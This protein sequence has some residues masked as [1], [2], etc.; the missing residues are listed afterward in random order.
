VA[1]KGLVRCRGAR[2]CIPMP[3]RALLNYLLVF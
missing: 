3:A 1:G 2:D